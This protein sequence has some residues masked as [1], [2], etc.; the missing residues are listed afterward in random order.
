MNIME[1]ERVHIKANSNGDEGAYSEKG[2]LNL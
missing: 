2:A 1:Y